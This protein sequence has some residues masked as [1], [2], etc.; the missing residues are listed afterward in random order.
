MV[1]EWMLPV[2]V[3]GEIVIC[4]KEAA[5]SWWCPKRSCS[6]MAAIAPTATR[7]ITAAVIHKPTRLPRSAATVA[8]PA[9]DDGTGVV[10]EALVRAAAVPEP[11][12][13]VGL[14][15]PHA[16]DEPLGAREESVSRFRRFKSPRSSAAVW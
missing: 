10:C 6:A 11:G 4:E 7:I 15:A 16:P 8:E 9:V 13:A 1:T 14:T 12:F 5:G 3:I 2:E